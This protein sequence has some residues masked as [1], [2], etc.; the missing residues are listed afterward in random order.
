MG[1][2][3][4][5]TKERFAFSM[6]VD[7]P[8]YQAPPF[9]YKDTRAATF[10]YETEAEAVA[11]LLPE[12]LEV[13]D[14]ATAVLSLIEYPWTTFG[15][16]NEAIL[17]VL[18]SHQGRRISYITQIFLTTEAPLAAGREIWGIPKKLAHIEFTRENEHVMGSVE[19]PKGLQ[20]CTGVMRPERPVDLGSNER[21]PTVCLR[22]IPSPEYGA[23]PSLAELIEIE[24]EQR[25]KD[26]WSGPGSVHF[27]GASELDP[28]HK[29]PV[30][31]MRQCTYGVSDMDLGYGRV[32]EKL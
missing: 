25:P 24:S 20:I 23:P 7:A 15:P 3:G 12:P 5:L 9:H 22:V 8:L 14:P 18:C 26:L 13:S 28:W 29:L 1:L 30:K 11:D 2:K 10:A 32:I 6:P 17:A 4:R 31:A 27:T 19:R 21:T 16:Y